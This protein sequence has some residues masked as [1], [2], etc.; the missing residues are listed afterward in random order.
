MGTGDAVG[1]RN[2][3]S[4]LER[5]QLFELF[6]PL[7]VRGRQCGEHGQERAPIDVQ[8]DV[9]QRRGRSVPIAREGDECA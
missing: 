7:H 9:L 1:N 4:M 3:V 6:G 8:T 5:A 2:G